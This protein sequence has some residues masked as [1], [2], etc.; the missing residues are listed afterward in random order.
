MKIS[1]ILAEKSAAYQHCAKTQKVDVYEQLR[2]ARKACK[3]LFL[4]E[5]Y[6]EIF[7]GIFSV[8]IFMS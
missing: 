2:S 3:V 7:P 8:K 4:R 5:L 1:Q 6:A